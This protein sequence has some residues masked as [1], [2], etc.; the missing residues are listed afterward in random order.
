MRDIHTATGEDWAATLDVFR[1]AATANS[2]PFTY[3]RNWLA[4]RAE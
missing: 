2:N 3:L 1:A 4:Q